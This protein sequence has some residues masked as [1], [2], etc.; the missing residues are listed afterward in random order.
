[1]KREIYMASTVSLLIALAVMVFIS[2]QAPATSAIDYCDY[3]EALA[4]STFNYCMQNTANTCD[5]CK[6]YCVSEC[7][8]WAGV[9]GWDDAQRAECAITG[10]LKAYWECTG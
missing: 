10:C 4:A 9:C 3:P 1:M 7:F 5:D 8:S 6:S 2:V